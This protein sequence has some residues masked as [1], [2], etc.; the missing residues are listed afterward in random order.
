[1]TDA[2]FES[3]EP[4]AAGKLVARMEAQARKL[5]ISRRAILRGAGIQDR[6]LRDIELGHSPSLRRV[7][8]LARAFQFP[9]GL[10]ELLGLDVSPVLAVDLRVLHCAHQLVTIVLQERGKAP[11]EDAQLFSRLTAIAY[12]RL[13]EIQAMDA[14]SLDSPVALHLVAATLRSEIQNRVIGGT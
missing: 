3:G 2:D 13:A 7:A 8:E 12:A 6:A 4:W 14:T 11:T 5:G 10:A 9:G 1:M